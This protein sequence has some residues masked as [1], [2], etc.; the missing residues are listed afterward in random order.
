MVKVLVVYDAAK[1]RQEEAGEK[2]NHGGYIWTTAKKFAFKELEK[3]KKEEIGY[4]RDAF[5]SLRPIDQKVLHARIVEEIS[6][7]DDLALRLGNSIGPTVLS[8]RGRLI[9]AFSEVSGVPLNN[10]KGNR[11]KYV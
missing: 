2:C 5:G 7:H 4:V 11:E 9:K 6:S 3:G 10:L 1:A 8:S